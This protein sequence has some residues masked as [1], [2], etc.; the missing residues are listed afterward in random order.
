MNLALGP[1]QPGKG[2]QGK[3]GGPGQGRRIHGRP[4][5]ALGGAAGKDKPA[6]DPAG[7]WKALEA[8]QAW[9]KTGQVAQTGLSFAAKVLAALKPAKADLCL[10]GMAPLRAGTPAT[11]I[12]AQCT[13]VIPV[14]DLKDGALY[15]RLNAATAKQHGLSEGSRVTLAGAGAPCSARVYISE[16]V[17]T[18]VVAVPLGFGHT[19]FDAFS[20]GK[21]DNFLSIMTATP[22]AGTD[23]TAWTGSEVKIA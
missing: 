4:G 16:N 19:A 10:A 23:M 8:G 20:K 6:F 5:H 11:G 22:E 18:G 3:G 14:T 12:P 2:P 17:M 13:T 15:V 21:G 9:V 7:K 1:R